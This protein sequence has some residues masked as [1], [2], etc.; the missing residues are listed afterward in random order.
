MTTR[1]ESTV[2]KI[3]RIA[4]YFVEFPYLIAFEKYPFLATP[5]YRELIFGEGAYDQDEKVE[6]K[7]YLLTPEFLPRTT[8]C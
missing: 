2:Q 4:S 6:A 1:S 8:S 3:F 5:E 7:E